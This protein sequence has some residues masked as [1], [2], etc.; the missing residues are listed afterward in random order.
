M[1]LKRTPKTTLDLNTRRN[2]ALEAVP[3]KRPTVRKEEREGKLYVTVEYERPRWQ[4][5]LGADL[6]CERSF[7]LDAYGR[8]VY[9]LCNGR[10]SVGKIVQRFSEQTHV[11]KPESEVAVTQFLRTLITK[12][13]V[14][15]EMEK[16]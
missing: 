14:V 3:R 4:R 7:G 12:G 6:T 10:W 11:S 16:L 9:E 5:V 1:I 2:A 13:L 15:V 8:M